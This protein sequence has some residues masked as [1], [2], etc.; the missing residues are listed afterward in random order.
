MVI[1][2]Q[3]DDLL[4]FF[5]TD[6]GF[7]SIVITKSHA[8]G[9]MITFISAGLALFPFDQIQNNHWR[10]AWLTKNELVD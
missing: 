6:T 7:L 3:S 1:S 9:G 5:S 2:V 4:P 8:G 10:A